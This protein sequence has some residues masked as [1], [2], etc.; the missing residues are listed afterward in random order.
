MIR[1]GKCGV[2][3]HRLVLKLHLR[4]S[5]SVERTITSIERTLIYTLY[6]AA[7][8]CSSLFLYLFTSPFLYSCFSGGPHISRQTVHSQRLSVER[9]DHFNIREPTRTQS[10]IPSTNSTIEEDSLDDLM[11]PEWHPRVFK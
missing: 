1:D 7:I 2:L 10:S 8:A 3:E 5:I 4:I 11:N 9:I 6:F